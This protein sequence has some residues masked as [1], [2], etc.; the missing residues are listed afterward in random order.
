MARLAS[1][2]EAGP[3]PR[4]ALAAWGVSSAA[5]ADE[6]TALDL[7]DV[8]ARAAQLHVQASATGLA[9][10]PAAGGVRPPAPSRH[11]LSR[12]LEQTAKHSTRNVAGG[13]AL[14]AHAAQERSK[15][16]CR[17]RRLRQDTTGSPS[18]LA[19]KSGRW[20]LPTAWA[21]PFRT[22][23]AVCQIENRE[24]QA[25]AEPTDPHGD[26]ATLCRIGPRIS[27]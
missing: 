10:G 23:V 12:F 7:P 25:C 6:A 5:D 26:Y 11:L 2:M 3:P 19:T 14:M 8:V 21:Y 9:D 17:E 4:A 24:G 16:E 20:Q 22:A 18:H 15:T 27:H 1:A 13:V